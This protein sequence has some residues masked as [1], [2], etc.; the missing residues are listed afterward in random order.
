MF[1]LHFVLVFT[2]LYD[3]FNPLTNQSKH[4]EH[5]FLADSI[6]IGSLRYLGLIG[7]MLL[8]LLTLC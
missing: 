5:V 4:L 3:C 8:V 6:L 1:H 2:K 7:Y